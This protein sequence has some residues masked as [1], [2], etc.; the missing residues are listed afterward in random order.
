MEKKHKQI[1]LYNSVIFIGFEFTLTIDKVVTEKQ[2]Q[3]MNKINSN[4]VI[5]VEGLQAVCKRSRDLI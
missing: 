4:D 1:L 2:W 3:K 5:K